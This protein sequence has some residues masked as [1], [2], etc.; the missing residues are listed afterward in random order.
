M[1]LFF[2]LRKAPAVINSMFLVTHSTVTL[3]VTS[4]SVASFT[5]V[6][7]KL[8]CPKLHQLKIEIFR[9]LPQECDLAG[10]KGVRRNIFNWWTPKSVKWRII[11]YIWEGS[12]LIG[13][14]S[15]FLVA[16]LYICVCIYTYIYTHIC[17]HMHTYT[18]I[19]IHTYICIHIYMFP[20]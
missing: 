8:V 19:H 5:T 20:L 18:Y 11:H 2:L 13:K 17:V 15:C 6:L 9:P 16:V 14:R 4:H 1:T 10:V 3:V 12:F 7:P